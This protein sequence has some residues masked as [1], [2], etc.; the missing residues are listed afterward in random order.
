MIEPIGEVVEKIFD[1]FTICQSKI[2]FWSAG[3]RSNLNG[4]TGAP[5]QRQ[6]R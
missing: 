2:T 6:G 5:D 3:Y 4:C 1:R